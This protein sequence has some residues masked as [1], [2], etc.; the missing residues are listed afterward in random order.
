M[1]TAEPLTAAETADPDRHAARGE[2]V[3]LFPLPLA[4]LEQFL[5][6]CETPGQPMIIRVVLRFTGQGQLEVLKSTLQGAM[7]RHPLLT[8][9]LEGTGRKRT[10]VRGKPCEPDCQ[11][12]SG[13]VFD[14]ETGLQRTFIDLRKDAGLQIAIR[15]YPDGVKVIMDTHHAVSDGNGL[16]QLITDWFHL[17]HC[18]LR[19]LTPKPPSMETDR[20]RQRDQF[21]Q[22]ANIAPIPF[23]DAVRNFFLTIRGRTARWTVPRNSGKTSGPETY[24]IEL[25]LSHE[26]C[27]AIHANLESAGILLNDFVLAASMSVFAKMSLRKFSRER[28]TVL[29]PTDLRRP[30]DRSLPAANRFGLAFMRRLP[31]ECEDLATLVAGLADEM[32]YVRSNYIGVEFLR[33]LASVS[34]LP[35][36]LGV[37]R[38]LGCFVPSM[39]WTCLGDVVRGAKRLM[40]WRD[41][42]IYTGDLK[43]VQATGMAPLAENVPL[44]IATCEVGKQITLAVRSNPKAVSIERTNEF[45]RRLTETL[46]EPLKLKKSERA[47]AAQPEDTTC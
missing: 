22:P 39:Q 13:S 37:F 40:E 15:Q 36:G 7:V 31:S 44:S 2:A 20:L 14:L 4:P 34:R 16:R 28:I 25:L 27:H 3:A 24:C 23:K 17:Y 29:N 38:R 8:C 21:P 9:R 33:G 19:G 18:E 12:V 47:A 1:S 5:L 42:S 35:G 43:F 10:W 30:S 6:D 32:T 41:K 45:A 46:C 26:E 11:R